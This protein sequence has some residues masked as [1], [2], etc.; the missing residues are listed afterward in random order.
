[1]KSNVLHIIWI[2]FFLV[3]CIGERSTGD[4]DEFLGTRGKIDV[5]ILVRE[6]DEHD[7]V[8]TVRFVVFDDASVTPTLDINELVT[9]ETE[10]RG[11]EKCLGKRGDHDRACRGSC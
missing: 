2:M 8:R 1:M 10:N 4:G 11:G 6:A 7:F 9:F 5:E 3:A